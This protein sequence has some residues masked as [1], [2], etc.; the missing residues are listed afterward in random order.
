MHSV[1]RLDQ[2]GAGVDFPVGRNRFVWTDQAISQSS[3]ASWPL[4]P[5]SRRGPV[6]DS[7]LVRRLLGPLEMVLV[8]GCEFHTGVPQ[9]LVV[10]RRYALVVERV[11]DPQQLRV[12]AQ[13][14]ARLGQDLS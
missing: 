2:S 8:E 13:P 10:L 12:P 9:E 6:G 5:V 11:A 14:P 3:P 4:G 1:W 7:G